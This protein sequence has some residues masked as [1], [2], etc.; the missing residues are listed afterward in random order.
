MSCLTGSRSYVH[1]QSRNSGRA[2]L[3]HRISPQSHKGTS[4]PISRSAKDK[5][6][7]DVVRSRGGNAKPKP[8]ED[9]KER[10]AQMEVANRESEAATASAPSVPPPTWAKEMEALKARLSSI[11]EERDAAVRATACKR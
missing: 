4:L 1:V 10:L 3:C 8:R 2:C 11:E 6:N 7:P 9:A 5:V